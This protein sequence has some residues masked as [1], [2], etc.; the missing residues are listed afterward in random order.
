MDKGGRDEAAMAR[1]P[2]DG[3]GYPLG[4]LSAW[5]GHNPRWVGIFSR[6]TGCALKAMSAGG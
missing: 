1:C 4:G 3:N 2:E 5:V 6:T